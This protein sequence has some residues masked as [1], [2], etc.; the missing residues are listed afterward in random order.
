M[1]RPRVRDPRDQRKYKAQRLKVLNAG[2]WSC[3]YCGQ[4]AD[5]VDH[6]IPIVKG[7]DPMS[8]E[9][10]VPACKRCNSAKGARS[11]G[12]FLFDRGHPPVFSAFLS[13][14]RSK[15][16]EDSPFTAKPVGN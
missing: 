13:P 16:H 7:G 3:H 1:S 9:N 14:T 8:I 12:V 4:D 5:T 2:G 6:V 10:M 15:I 11:E